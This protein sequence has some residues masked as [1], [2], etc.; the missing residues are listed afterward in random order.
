MANNPPKVQEFINFLNKTKKD[1]KISKEISD[2]LEENSTQNI[3]KKE[4]K[5]DNKNA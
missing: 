5:G 2:W 4:E 3:E 1:I